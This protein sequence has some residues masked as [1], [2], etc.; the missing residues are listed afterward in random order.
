[1]KQPTDASVGSDFAIKQG[2]VA[3]QQADAA[4][5]QTAAR[6]GADVTPAPFEPVLRAAL[7][8]GQGSLYVRRQLAQGG[9]TEIADE[10]PWW[11]PAKIAGRYV[12][13]FLARWAED[14]ESRLSR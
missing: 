11:P 9:E 4:A 10:P 7:L 14:A 5:S 6:A 1:V 8:T 12:A 13:P 2:G 3:T